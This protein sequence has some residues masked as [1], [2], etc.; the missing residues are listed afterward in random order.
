MLAS[1]NRHQNLLKKVWMNHNVCDSDACKKA[2]Y[3]QSDKRNSF[4]Q[5]ILRHFLTLQFSRPTNDAAGLGDRRRRAEN[6]KA[7][8]SG[9]VCAKRSPQKKGK[10]C[11]Y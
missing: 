8:N 7:N 10:H 9:H 4:N 3:T 2:D 6:K 1:K 11:T 5:P